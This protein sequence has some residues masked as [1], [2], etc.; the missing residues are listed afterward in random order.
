MTEQGKQ[1]HQHKDT[2]LENWRK[3]PEEHQASFLLIL[4]KDVLE[5]DYQQWILEALPLIISSP[6]S[7]KQ[8]E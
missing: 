6:P 8:D 3:L 1:I 5:S 4:L 7:N 2:I